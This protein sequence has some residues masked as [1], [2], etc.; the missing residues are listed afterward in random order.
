MELTEKEILLSH[1]Y[2]KYQQHHPTADNINHDVCAILVNLYFENTNLYTTLKLLFIHMCDEVN[3][4]EF[5]DLD[6]GNDCD[7]IVFQIHDYCFKYEVNDQK[8][9]ITFGKFLTINEDRLYNSHDEMITEFVSF[10]HSCIMITDEDHEHVWL[11]LGL[12]NMISDEI[13]RIKKG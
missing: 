7:D 8:L 2:N 12:I 13:E 6:L 10:I 4:E 1:I 11:R 9:A 3:D 5:W